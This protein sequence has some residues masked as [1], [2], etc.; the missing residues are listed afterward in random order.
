MPRAEGEEEHLQPTLRVEQRWVEGGSLDLGP[1]V[2]VRNMQRV[3]PTSDERATDDSLIQVGGHQVMP[4]AEGEEEHL[5][6]TMRLE[7]R[8][9]EGGRRD[10][11]PVDG[12]Q[13]FSKF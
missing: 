4:R 1:E 12:L 13:Q 2:V 7:H 3:T 11:G 9:V 6:P 5:Q 10:L 8:W